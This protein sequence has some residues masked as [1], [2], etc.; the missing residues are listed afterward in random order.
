[1][2]SGLAVPAHNFFARANPC[3][4]ES[5]RLEYTY[6][7]ERAVKLLSEIGIT[8]N[9]RGEMVDQDG[10]RIE[11]T[12]NVGAEN[13]IGVDMAYSVYGL[14]A[15]SDPYATLGTDSSWYGNIPAGD[16]SLS[17]PYYD[18]TVA[19]NCPN[20][21]NIQFTVEFH[22]SND[23]IWVSNTNVLVYA[24]EFVCQNYTITGGNGNG[25]LEPGET[26]DVVIIK[27][28]HGDPDTCSNKKA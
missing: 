13:N 11:F 19:T 8:R 27:W 9:S 10:N 7:P 20:N 1:M 16:S 6:N 15:G 24:A 23:S 5:I 26:V 3:Y 22:D 25:I 28:I 18:F 12:M 2:Y 21:H 14:L 4:D 17:N